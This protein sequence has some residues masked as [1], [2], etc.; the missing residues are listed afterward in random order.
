MLGKWSSGWD[1]KLRLINKQDHLIV[2]FGKPFKTWTI[3]H[4]W[5][6]IIDTL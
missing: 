2:L 4:R 1:L 3:V 5:Q 6:G